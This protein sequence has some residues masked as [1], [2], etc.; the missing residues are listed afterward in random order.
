M[1]CSDK[2][3]NKIKNRET[4]GFKNQNNNIKKTLNQKIRNIKIETH[5]FQKLETKK[6]KHIE[7]N[8]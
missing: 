8:H 3:R 4:H 2:S 1:V 7:S 6:Q 5:G